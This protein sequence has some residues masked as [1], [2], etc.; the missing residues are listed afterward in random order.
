MC[1]LG[2][3]VILFLVVTTSA[4]DCLGRL[5]SEMTECVEWNVKLL[6]T[7]RHCLHVLRCENFDT[8]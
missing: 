7:R 4:V 2:T 5:V 1:V 8:L 3:C 6:L